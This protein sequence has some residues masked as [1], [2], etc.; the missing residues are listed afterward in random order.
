MHPSIDVICA[1]CG[2]EQSNIIAAAVNVQN[3]DRFMWENSIACVK[4]GTNLFF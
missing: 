1:L 4:S 2:I 3:C